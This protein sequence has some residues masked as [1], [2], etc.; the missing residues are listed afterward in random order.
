MKDFVELE[1]EVDEIESRSAVDR[2]IE[3]LEKLQKIGVYV[4][5]IKSKDTIK[6]I[7]QKSG[8]KEEQ[9]KEI[10]LNQN[11][12]IGNSKIDIARTYRGEGNLKKLTEEQIERLRKLGIS[13]DKQNMTQEFIMKLEMLQEIGVDVSKVTV[14]DTIQTLAQKSGIKEERVKE[15]GL[16]PNDKIGNSKNHITQAYRGK[17][18]C[19]KP[20][21]EQVERLKELGISLE[22]KRRTRKEI[23]EASISSLKDIEIADEEDKALKELAEKTK[24]GGILISE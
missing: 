14:K 13:L 22:K 3:K 8:I 18:E 20:T 6:T 4:S 19:K 12:K 15:I 24:E 7:A 21:D 11:D 16:N 17:G 5:K 9:L 23:A 2:F 1:N 10:G